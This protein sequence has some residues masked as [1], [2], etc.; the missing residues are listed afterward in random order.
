LNPTLEP[1]HWQVFLVNSDASGLKQITHDDYNDQVPKWS[2]DGN[3]I[4]FFSDKT[5]R[6]QLYTM[7][8]DGSDWQGLLTGQREDSAGSWSHD[9][10]RILFTADAGHGAD[11]Y[12]FDFRTKQEKQLTTN[13]PGLG[14]PFWSP[15]EKTIAFTMRRGEQSD[16]Y[17]MNADGS[18][19]RKLF[20]AHGV[21]R[22]R[23][24]SQASLGQEGPRF[25]APGALQRLWPPRRELLPKLL[26]LVGHNVF[27]ELIHYTD[28][29]LT[30]R[31]IDDCFP[32][33]A[34]S[35]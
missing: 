1:P 27:V 33:A 6:N 24:G 31:D 28:R 5:G 21:T 25:T 11:I 18:N 19:Q 34:E 17:F 4:M 30:K 22:G 23:S 14:V 12:T 16:V 15:D 20:Q 7:R 32:M 35:G 10:Q 2:P 29:D 26:S 3:R 9:E 8:A 13:A